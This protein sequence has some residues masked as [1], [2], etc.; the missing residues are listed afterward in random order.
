MNRSQSAHRKTRDRARRLL[1][2]I[3]ISAPLGFLLS[4]FVVPVTSQTMALNVL[5]IGLGLVLLKIRTWTHR[6]HFYPRLLWWESS[7]RYQA[8]LRVNLR[9]PSEGHNY[10]GE[11]LDIS[12]SGVFVSLENSPELSI[13]EEHHIHLPGGIEVRGQVVRRAPNGYG[14][15]FVRVGWTQRSL[16]KNFVEQLARDPSS[17]LR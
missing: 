2:L 15:R 7:P 3:L 6:P 14:L 16:I 10:P 9:N 4:H 5:L 12:R 8:Q 1:A 17:L 13:G 11:I